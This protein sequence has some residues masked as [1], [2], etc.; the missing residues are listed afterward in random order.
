MSTYS[1]IQMIY[2]QWEFEFKTNE[3]VFR[4]I[5]VIVIIVVIN[6]YS[7]LHEV[8]LWVHA[9]PVANYVSFNLF[10]IEANNWISLINF[11]ENAGK[12]FIITKQSNRVQL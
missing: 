8:L 10:P 6:L 11:H 2:I 12:L 5:I 9:V 3:N 7:N 1:Y 4:I